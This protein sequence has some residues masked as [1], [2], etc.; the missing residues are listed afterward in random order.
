MHKQDKLYGVNLGGWL[1][2]EKWITPS[3]FAGTDAMDEYTFMH[4]KNANEKI[5]KH[6]RDFITEEDFKWMRKSGLNAVRIPVGYWL[7]ETQTP[8]TPTIKYLDWAVRMAAKYDLKVLIDLHAAPGSQNGQ[9]HSGRIGMAGWYK[10]PEYQQQTISV[11]EKIA[12]HYHDQPAVWGIELLN[13]PKPGIFQRQLRQFYKKSYEKLTAVTSPG[14]RIVFHDAFRPLFFS[15]AIKSRSSHPSVMD[16]HSYHFGSWQK[17]QQPLP[18]Y[19]YLM[20]KYKYWLSFLQRKQ[21]III[22]EWSLVIS[23]KTLRRYSK[24]N[25]IK[26]LK[27]HAEVQLAAF[28]NTAGW[29]YWTYKTESKDSWNFRHLIEDEIISI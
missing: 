24:A 27:R 17:Q 29:F 11:L 13:E 10:N 23:H 14:T 18:S 9:D 21:P 25:E 12:Q 7:F 28:E 15:G 8:Y 26:Y 5:E 6:R 4:T 16:I 1:I 19:F 20:G 3:L 22:G 2:V